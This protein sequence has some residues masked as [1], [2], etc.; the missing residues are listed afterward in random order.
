MERLAALAPDLILTT[1]Y[2]QGLRGRLEELAPV[3]SFSIYDQ[4][5]QPYRKAQEATLALGQRLERETQ[6]RQ[7]VEQ[8]ESAFDDLA[9][10]LGKASS[11]PLLLLRFMDARHVRVYGDGSLFDAVLQRSDIPNAWQGATNA[12]GFQTVGI[13]QLA[14]AAGPETRIL[15]FDPLP[16]EVRP[17]LESSPLWTRLPAVEAGRFSVLPAVLMFGMLP[18]ALRFARVLERHLPEA[19]REG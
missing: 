18:S 17:T 15:T 5:K 4:D 9:K 8:T 19:G 1:P 11:E 3:L 16:E 14:E 7:L 13:E 2:V 10:S 12:W 6:A